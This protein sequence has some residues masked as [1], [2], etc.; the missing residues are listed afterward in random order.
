MRS[1]C[2]ST[3]LIRDVFPD[4]KWLGENNG[5][6]GDQIAQH[7]L[8]GEAHAHAR[9]A[10]AGDERPQLHAELL[11]RNQ[12]REQHDGQLG[13]ANEKHS[14]RRLHLPLGQRGSEDLSHAASDKQPNNKDS[15]WPRGPSAPSP[16][17][18]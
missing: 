2:P 8:H 14:H 4:T 1:T 6:A 13:D 16:W 17:S 11:D 5:Q 10:E 18:A 12:D 3:W 9:H 15:R 7:A